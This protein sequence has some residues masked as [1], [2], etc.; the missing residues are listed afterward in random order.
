M[1]LKALNGWTD[2]NFTELLQLL[3]DMLAKGNTLTN[4]NYE[5]KNILCPM[6]MEYKK[7]HACPNDRSTFSTYFLIFCQLFLLSLGCFSVSKITRFTLSYENLS[8]NQFVFKPRET[9]CEETL[10]CYQCSVKEDCPNFNY[11]KSYNFQKPRRYSLGVL[12]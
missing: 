12:G 2:K 6:D 4:H 5:P 10:T 8:S 1:N 11:K 7:M 9:L 3:K